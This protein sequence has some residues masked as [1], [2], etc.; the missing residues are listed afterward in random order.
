RL[1][2]RTRAASELAPGSDATASALGWSSREDLSQRMDRLEARAGTLRPP[3]AFPR[4]LGKLHSRLRVLGQPTRRKT[5][6]RQLVLRRVQRNGAEPQRRDATDGSEG[7]RARHALPRMHA[8]HQ[9]V[10][11]LAADRLE[12]LCRAVARSALTTG[13]GLA[14]RWK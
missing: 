6:V 9:A 4:T 5:V 3:H 14:S 1:D 10:R 7:Q 2:F 11:S 13:A 12:V 8:L